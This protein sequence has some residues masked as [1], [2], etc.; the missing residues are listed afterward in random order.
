MAEV[1]DEHQ[2]REARRELFDSFPLTGSAQDVTR[3]QKALVRELMATEGEISAD[4]RPWRKRHRRLV[5]IYGDA[6]AHT[7]L[8][9]YAMRQLARNTGKPPHLSGQGKSFELAIECLEAV[10]D[11]GLP[12]VLADLTNV[13]RN[14]D[15]IVC[16]H[17][18]LPMI[19]ECKLSKVKEARFQRQGRRGRQLA[20]MESIASF[21][22]K[23]RGRIV[24]DELDRVTVE[25]VTEAKYDHR[26]VAQIVASAMDHMPTIIVKSDQEYL[27]SALRGETID[28]SVLDD[29]G[30]I[31]SGG[32]VALGDTLDRLD[33]PWPDVIPPILWQLAPEARWGLMEGDISVTHVVTIDAFV[34][35]KSD[36]AQVVGLA[37]M[38]GGLPWGYEILVGDEKITLGGNFLL[39]V[40]YNH[41]TIAS[42]GARFLELAAKT[43]AVATDAN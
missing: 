17:P 43:L 14:G 15:L 9:I 33:E 34:G 18:H 36:R 19:F 31:R 12:A 21:L 40:I 16:G 6:L 13:L 11:R 4:N 3:Y 35:L 24:G 8:S 27:C 5:R 25:V 2:L 37:D 32:T 23:G 39:S 22:Q 38:P 10:S 30:G 1:R 7:L 20:R 42:A 26:S 41:E 29:W 28:M